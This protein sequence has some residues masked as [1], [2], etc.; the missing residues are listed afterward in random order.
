MSQWLK[1]STARVI[2]FG[3][4]FLDVGDPADAA[5]IASIIAAIDHPTTGIMLSKNG[6][7]AAIRHPIIT[8][9]AYDAR[10]FFKVTLDTTDTNT[11]G[12][13]LVT[14]SESELCSFWEEFMVVPSQVWESFFGAD[15]LEVTAVGAGTGA[16]AIAWD[17]TLTDADTGAPLDAAS[18]WITTDAAG[19]NVVASSLTNSNG[20]A[21]FY[22]DAATYFVWREKSGYNFTNPDIESVS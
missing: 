9:S 6:G 1:Q 8:P 17:Y 2:T 5:Y 16:G 12:T 7:A 15:K 22:L 4:P 13:L 14:H 21:T 10:G 19:A 11:L 18:V 3:G 20:V